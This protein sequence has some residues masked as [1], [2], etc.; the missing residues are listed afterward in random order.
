[1][2]LMI[3]SDIHGSYLHCKKMIEL[4][5]KE[6]ADR[7]ILLGDILYHGP[8]NDLPEG[9]DPKSVARTLNDMKDKICCVRGNC[10]SE[11]D[12]MMLEFPILSES[13]LL[14]LEN[15]LVFVT[16]GHIYNQ[17]NPPRIGKKDILLNGHTHVPAAEEGSLIYPNP[18]SISLPKK[19][20]P[21]S[22]MTYSDKTFVIRDFGQ[23]PILT[24]Q[25]D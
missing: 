11:V 25:M 7:L 2:K 17:K 21:A 3:A 4:F 23:N 16:H 9:Y 20:N 14:L 13:L 18:G 1:M 5:G 10:D 22:Y 6:K 19:G 8:R 15:R 12:Q 24:C